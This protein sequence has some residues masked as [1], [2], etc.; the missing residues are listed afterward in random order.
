[1]KI[2]SQ[3]LVASKTSRHD[4]RGEYGA[5]ATLSLLGEIAL[6]HFRLKMI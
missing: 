3:V 2:T 1:M 4:H 6:L 5:A